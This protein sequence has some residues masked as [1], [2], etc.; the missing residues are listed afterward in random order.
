MLVPLLIRLQQRLIIYQGVFSKNKLEDLVVQVL[1]I[2]SLM[3][4]GEQE[5]SMRLKTYDSAG[6]SHK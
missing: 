5:A 1:D 6:R 4:E 2:Y 3:Y